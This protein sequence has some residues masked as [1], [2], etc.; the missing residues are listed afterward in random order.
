MMAELQTLILLFFVTF[1]LRASCLPQIA[2]T[3]TV[4]SNVS[5]GCMTGGGDAR[6]DSS[7]VKGLS[8]LFCNKLLAHL[9]GLPG[10]WCPPRRLNLQ[11]TRTGENFGSPE[12]PTDLAVLP[13]N[14]NY[15]ALEQEG[16]VAVFELTIGSSYIDNNGTIHKQGQKSQCA[17]DNC[18]RIFDAII[19]RCKSAPA[20]LVQSL[21]TCVRRVEH[22]LRWRLQPTHICMW[23]LFGV[24]IELYQQSRQPRLLSLALQMATFLYDNIDLI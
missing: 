18:L 19:N 21:L 8:A 12:Y 9:L 17:S 16:Y 3:T 20:W 15:T 14:P 6:M 1:I 2:P 10:T 22:A 4:S 23:R 13:N 11:L 7:T 5:I 24:H